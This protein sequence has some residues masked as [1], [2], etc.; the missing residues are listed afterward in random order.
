M[1]ERLEV[2]QSPVKQV[3]Q[4]VVFG[5]DGVEVARRGRHDVDGALQPFNA[6]VPARLEF[7]QFRAVTLQ[8]DV[9]DLRHP[10]RTRARVGLF[11]CLFVCERERV[12]ER[13][14]FYGGIYTQGRGRVGRGAELTKTRN[15]QR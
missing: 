11:V 6:S 9:V 13:G 14:R 12:R 1:E 10:T 15:R 4:G 2:E 5:V 3:D 7:F 8:P